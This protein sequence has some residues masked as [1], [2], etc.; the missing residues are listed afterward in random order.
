MAALTLLRQDHPL[1]DPV[2]QLERLEAVPLSASFSERVK[3]AGLGEHLSA[4]GVDIL[5]INVGRKCNQTCKHCHVD[6]GPDREEVMPDAV[7]DKVL[8]LIE[9]TDVKTF[10]ITGGAPELHPRFEEMVE[11]AVA[12]GK[13]VIDRCNLTILLTR[14]YAHLP[15]FFAKH[16]VEVVCSLPFPSTKMTDAQRGEGVF[17]QSIEALKRLNAEGYG[18]PGTG[19]SL[20][21]VSNPVGAFL[22][23]PQADLEADFRRALREQYAVEFSSLI[24]IT[25]MPISRYLEWLDDSGNTNRYM[26]KLERAFNPSAASGVMCRTTL[27]VGYDGRL[28]DCD[29]NQMLE[30]ELSDNEPRTIF[31][32]ADSAALAAVGK[33]EIRVAPHCFGC[34]AGQGSSCGGATA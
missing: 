16:G 12:A 18:M 24:A 15:K 11:R 21:L 32:I 22:P 8:D 34:T 29:F 20:V 5:Q 13:H 10:D 31:D 1:S 7:V 26:S 25:N 28:F 4:T 27:S 30:L 14:P 19:L 9:N 2:R 6:A 23:A 33:R 3:S 17:A